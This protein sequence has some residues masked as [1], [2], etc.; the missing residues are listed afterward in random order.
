[1]Y[2]KSIF[3]LDR[4]SREAEVTVSD[5]HV[6]LLCFSHPC[7]KDINDNLSEPIHCLDAK[8]IVLAL[9][10]EAEGYEKDENDYF[11]SSICG[12][13]IDKKNQIVLLGAI[14]LCLDNA[15]MPGDILEGSYISFRASRLDVF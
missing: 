6:S 7:N 5:G 11:A 2:I 15:D 10:N 1:M 3:W 14:K 9:N 12:K 4:E 8:N 13:L